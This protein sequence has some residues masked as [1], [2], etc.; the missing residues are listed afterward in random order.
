MSAATSNAAEQVAVIGAGSFGRAL[1]R[2]LAAGGTAVTIYAPEPFPPPGPD[3]PPLPQGTT[4][5]T[6]LA[7]A[8][9][10]GLLF[11]CAPAQAARAVSRALGEVVRGDQILVHAARGLD[12]ATGY[13]VTQVVHEETCLRKLGVVGGALRASALDQ[14]RTVAAVVASHFEE[15][16]SRTAALL[17]TPTFRVLRSPD[18][19]G[20]ELAGAY[21]SLCAVWIGIVD[22]LDLGDAARAMVMTE[23]LSEATR[24]ATRLGADP[25]TFTGYAGVGDLVATAGDPA[26]A[27]HEAGALLSRSAPPGAAA[28]LAPEAAA[29]AAGA[30]VLARRLGV[31]A[32]GAEGLRRLFADGGD[33]DATLRAVLDNIAA[34]SR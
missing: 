4:V 27:E 15:V 32:P 11:L 6:D 2:R 21:R 20:V 19:P 28:A 31:P 22:T 7:A 30:V 18:V 16:S 26:G 25:L 8:A 34:G 33:A 10:A 9:R 17:R 3:E 14:G 13:T 24:L 5:T 12:A 29:A 1:A 23:G